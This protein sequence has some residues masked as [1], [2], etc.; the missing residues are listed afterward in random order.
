MFLTSDNS[1][2]VS[3]VPYVKVR[4]FSFIY[5]LFYSQSHHTKANFLDPSWLN[6]STVMSCEQFGY[7]ALHI[8]KKGFTHVTVWV[9]C[10]HVWKIYERPFHHMTSWNL[11]V[12]SSKHMGHHVISI[13]S[14]EKKFFTSLNSL[15]EKS[16]VK[17]RT[18]FPTCR[19]YYLKL[20]IN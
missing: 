7:T 5:F 18:A 8:S 9:Q 4:A 11:H 3:K 13:W 6:Y 19:S 17:Y 20:K 14:R 10:A 1:C 15:C 2:V 12:N 16:Y